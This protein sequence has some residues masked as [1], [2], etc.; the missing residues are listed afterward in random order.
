MINERVKYTANTGVGLLSAANAN[1][2]GTGTLVSII[3][4]NKLKSYSL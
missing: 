3:I 2:D 4:I 1:I